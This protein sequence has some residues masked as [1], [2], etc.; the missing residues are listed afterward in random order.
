MRWRTWAKYKAVRSLQASFAARRLCLDTRLHMLLGRY[1]EVNRAFVEAEDPVSRKT[2]YIVRHMHQQVRKVHG[3]RALEPQREG[4][5][6]CEN[7]L[8]AATIDSWGM[9]TSA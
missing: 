8:P 9:Q 3:H 6:D 4:V 5:D 7:C 2:Y 1:G